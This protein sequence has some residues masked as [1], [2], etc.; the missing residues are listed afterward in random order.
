MVFFSRCEPPVLRV[1]CRGEV[2]RE[3]E[4]VEDVKKIT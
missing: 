3:R 1:L 2:I 4:A